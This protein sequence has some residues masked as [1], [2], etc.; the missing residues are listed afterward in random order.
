ML[1][2]TRRVLLLTAACVAGLE[3]RATAQ[4]E[5]PVVPPG[6]DP[7]AILLAPVL[8][9]THPAGR[10][11]D[12]PKPV[13]RTT[14]ERVEPAAR[15][16]PIGDT[17]IVRVSDFDSARR[18]VGRS[19]VVNGDSASALRHRAP[20]GSPATT[21]EPTTASAGLTSIADA[22]PTSIVSSR[23]MAKSARSKSSTTKCGQCAR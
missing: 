6:A 21:T 17:G 20:C 19:R 11:S 18:V 4:S 13:E 7:A 14:S 23:L 1:A 15:L 2:R 8:T 16:A 22:G 10:G 5:S 12:M 3:L 9:Q